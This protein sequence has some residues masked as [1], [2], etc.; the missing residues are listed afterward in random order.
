VG[1][2]I[3][4]RSDP[5]TREKTRVTAAAAVCDSTPPQLP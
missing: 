5:Q 3:R 4:E 1:A 2:R